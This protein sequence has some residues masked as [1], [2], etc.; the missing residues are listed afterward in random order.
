[1]KYC[2]YEFENMVRCM[3]L[4]YYDKE[5]WGKYVC[6][7]NLGGE[8]FIQSINNCPYCGKHLRISKNK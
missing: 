7:F 3:G 2:C 8:E 4:I 5:N 6:R 1:M